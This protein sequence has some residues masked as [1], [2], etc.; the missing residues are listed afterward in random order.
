MT[1]QA[2]KAKKL[3]ERCGF[4]RR[5]D[6]HYCYPCKRRIEAKRVAPDP[7]QMEFQYQ[8]LWNGA[9]VTPGVPVRKEG[10]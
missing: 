10:K 9:Q 6:D 2:K 1:R 4:E 3:C 8:G 7:S 5:K